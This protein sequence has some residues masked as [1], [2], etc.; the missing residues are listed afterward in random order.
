MSDLPATVLLYK[1]GK[2]IITGLKSEEEIFAA[3]NKLD[4]I[5]PSDI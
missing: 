5:L 3:T 1:N 4:K 2:A